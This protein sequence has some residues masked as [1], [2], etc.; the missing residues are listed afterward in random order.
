MLMKAITELKRTITSLEAMI[1][2]DRTAR[3]YT[4]SKDSVIKLKVN[5][6]ISL[7]GNTSRPGSAIATVG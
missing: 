1:R 3:D 5:R 6:N 7:V 2:P 4:L